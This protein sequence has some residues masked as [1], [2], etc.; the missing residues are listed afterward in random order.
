MLLHLSIQNYALIRHLEIDFSSGLTV[1][2]GETGA[3]KS[4]LL[5]ALDLILGKRAD[6]RV[7]MDNSAKCI[8]EGQFSANK[9]EL[10]DILLK[11]D[12]DRFDPLLLRRE[13]NAQGKSRAFV[14]DTPVTLNILKEIG[15][16]L[17]DIHSQNENLNL[18]DSDFQFS[19]IDSF[20]GILP[21]VKKYKS[22]FIEFRL[23]AERLSDLEEAEKKAN[24]ERDYLTF[25]SEELLQA[26]LKVGELQQLEQEQKILEHAGEIKGILNTVASQLS[27]DEN[28]LMPKL[29]EISK[30]ISKLSDFDEVLKEFSQRITSSYIDLEDLATGL[31]R[32][33]ENVVFDQERT[34]E[35]TE[36]LN[37]INTLLRKHQVNDVDE[38]MM[39]SQKI[40]SALL[41]GTSLQN[42]IEKI[43]K[44]LANSQ[45]L[46]EK[47]AQLISDKR[48]K[49]TT[50][51]E[52]QTTGILS[53]LGMPN[54]SIKVDIR[55]SNDINRNGK[56]TIKLLFNANKGGELQELS[57]VASGGEKSRMM[58][59]LKSLLS[60]KN[61]IPTIIFDE[62]DAGVSGAIADKVGDIIKHMADHM[63]VIA[64]THLPQIAGKGNDHFKVYKEDLE[65]R[66]QTFIKKLTN[67]ERVMEIAKMMS[68]KK[69][70]ES[71]VESARILLNN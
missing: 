61:T 64:I 10:D 43:K 22:G 1:I 47:E 2:T 25:L 26:H 16:L 20:A 19:V 28:G 55:N 9:S 27:Q 12:L 65:T 3:G 45:G 21:E 69:M 56:D 52:K 36:R 50:E 67:D 62:I 38:L 7:L 42:E 70:S 57:L 5:G 46:L 66:T 35:V 8:V 39:V 17:I 68:G 14:N 40:D 60:D 23:L 11:N 71:T 49:I 41:E 37:L 51:F 59:T 31:S 29:K 18:S 30:A 34:E 58:L 44:E 15:D 48:K 53:N 4:I 54:A 6:T 24:A 32:Y 13:I 33:E 63:Q